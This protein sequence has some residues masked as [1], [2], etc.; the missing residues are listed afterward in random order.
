MDNQL[1][2]PDEGFPESHKFWLITE[3]ARTDNHI[4]IKNKYSRIWGQSLEDSTLNEVFTK[5]NKAI[6]ELKNR[7]TEDLE[8]HPMSSEYAR[9]DALDGIKKD[10]IDG[11]PSGQ[12]DING[13]VCVKVELNAAIAAIRAIGEIKHQKALENL[14]LLQIMVQSERLKAP[15]TPTNTN[16]KDAKPHMDSVNAEVTEIKSDMDDVNLG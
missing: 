15:G 14:K 10:A 13:N 2:V 3:L 6:Q 11:V 16:D 8:S 7:I 4:E 12:L 5:N 1:L 9:I